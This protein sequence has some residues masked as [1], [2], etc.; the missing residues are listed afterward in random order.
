MKNTQMECMAVCEPGSCCFCTTENET[1]SV[2]D[3]MEVCI[4]YEPCMNMKS[5]EGGVDDYYF[6]FDLGHEVSANLLV[7]ARIF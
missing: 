4:M 6:P 1:S 3:N 7:A 2:A 5:E